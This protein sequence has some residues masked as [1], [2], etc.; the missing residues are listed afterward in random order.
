MVADTSAPAELGTMVAPQDNLPSNI[1]VDGNYFVVV[2][3]LS[4]PFTI[5]KNT[6]KMTI[7]FDVTDA[8]VFNH[9]NPTVVSWPGPVSVT[10]TIE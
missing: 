7:S 9:D 8:I 6:A 3:T 5:G 1:T 2:E 4:A 10:M